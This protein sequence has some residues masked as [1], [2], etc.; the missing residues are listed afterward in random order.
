MHT[1]GCRIMWA[2]VIRQEFTVTQESFSC[3]IFQKHP[4]EIFWTFLSWTHYLV[5]VHTS[6]HR[7]L[8]YLFAQPP[9]ISRQSVLTAWL[10]LVQNSSALAEDLEIS[11]R[12]PFSGSFIKVLSKTDPDQPLRSLAVYPFP[13]SFQTNVRF[14]L[15]IFVSCF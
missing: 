2:H 10:F 12:K 1:F 6:A 11:L 7:P 4:F 15:F 9:K 14:Y 5:H 3:V 8:S 13:F